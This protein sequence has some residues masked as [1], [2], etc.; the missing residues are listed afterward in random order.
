LLRAFALVRRKRM[1][2]LLIFG[3][4]EERDTLEKLARELGVEEDVDLPGFV[5][6]S[7]SYLRRATAFVLSSL[8]EG[9]PT[10][11]IEALASGC[12][13][14]STDCPGGAREIL[15]NGKYGDLVPVGDA[16]AMADA[17]CR[18]LDGKAHSVDQEWLEQF[19][20]NH[21]VD[22]TLRMLGLPEKP[23]MNKV[24]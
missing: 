24:F 14:I 6:N 15:A 3:E 9:L 18:I 11:L 21:V 10:V 7:F 5:E 22:R 20:L 8:Y 2:R 13:V 12:S 23:Q 16:D 17:I 4:G 1:A 19:E